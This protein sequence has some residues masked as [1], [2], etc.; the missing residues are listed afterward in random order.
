MQNSPVWQGV[1]AVMAGLAA[2]WGAAA[3]DLPERDTRSPTFDELMPRWELGDR[4]VVETVSQPLQVRG[5]TSTQPVCRPIQWQF[6]V[7]RFEKSLTDDCYRVEINCLAA[8]AE[9]PSTV[10]WID[11]KSRALRQIQ[12]QLPVPGGFRTVTQSYEFAGGQPSPVLGP[13]TALPVDLPLFLGDQAKG[14]Q[15]FT[16]ETRMGP[17][18]VKN[19]G[20][21]GF[22]HQIEQQVTPVASSEV[23]GLL[24]DSYAKSLTE[25]PTVEVRLK[26]YDRQ[27]RQLWQPGLPWP[28]YSDSG[29]TVCRLVKVIPAGQTDEQ[30]REP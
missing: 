27:V 4:W 22:A 13:L 10:L 18:G 11:R 24:S 20:E 14:M 6:A 12:T 5:E 25:Q 30:Q 26:A 7:Q 3:A 23:K 2:V 8:G 21:L 17:P 16:Y 15:T 9:Q 19:V 29:S 28:V 1:L